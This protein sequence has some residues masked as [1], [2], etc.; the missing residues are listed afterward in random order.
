MGLVVDEQGSAHVVGQGDEIDTADTQA[1]RRPPV[2]GQGEKRCTNRPFVG[3]EWAR[4]GR[5]AWADMMREATGR[6]AG[7]SGRRRLQC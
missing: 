2:G 3:W 7:T 6:P 1:A 4:G 5:S